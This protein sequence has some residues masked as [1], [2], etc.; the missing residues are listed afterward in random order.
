MAVHGASRQEIHHSIPSC[1]LR[2]MDRADARPVL[3]GEGLQLWL[4]YE[5]EALR[6]GVAPDISRVDLAVLVEGSMVP[7]PPRPARRVR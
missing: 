4:E 7:L 3:D 1:L 5:L 2:L 6:Y